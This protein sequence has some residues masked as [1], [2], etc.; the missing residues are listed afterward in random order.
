MHEEEK[1]PTPWE[2]GDPK[3]PVVKA[4]NM[5]KRRAYWHRSCHPARDDSFYE[6]TNSADFR[7]RCV[8]VSTN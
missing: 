1:K 7:Q 8:V 5:E 3:L 4:D 6:K 2:A